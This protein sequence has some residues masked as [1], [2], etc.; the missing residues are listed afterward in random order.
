MAGETSPDALRLREAMEQL[1]VGGLARTGEDPWLVADGLGAAAPES[2]N[3]RH[4]IYRHVPQ[5]NLS[6]PLGSLTT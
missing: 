5:S 6:Q 4:A 3:R 1:A 2:P